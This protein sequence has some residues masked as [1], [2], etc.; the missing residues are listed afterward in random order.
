[1]KAFTEIRSV[2]ET[3]DSSRNKT[4]RNLGPVVPL[5]Q[6]EEVMSDLGAVGGKMGGHIWERDKVPGQCWGSL[7]FLFISS[8]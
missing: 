1:M 7:M 2:L 3:E 6:C 4:S 5:F 8:C